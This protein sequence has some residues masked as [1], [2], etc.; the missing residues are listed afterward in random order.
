[1]FAPARDAGGTGF[2]LAQLDAA[3]DRRGPVLWVQEAAAACEAGRPCLRGVEAMLGPDRPLMRVA[4][5]SPAEA[6]WA[7][8]EG[9]GCGALSAIVGEIRGT[10]RA[11]DFT[12]TKRLMLRAERSGVP[13]WLLRLDAD[14]PG[15]SVAPR[16]WRLAAAPSAPNPLDARAPGDARWRAELFRA[17]G[18]P[19]GAWVAAHDRAAHRV[20][21]AAPLRDGALVAELGGPAPAPARAVG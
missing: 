7:I 3:R 21:L 20:D 15:L 12:A 18:A 1:V 6:L 11:L 17:R 16:R 2:V 5:G 13:L 19:P 14:A 9:L 8:E 4:A 10:P